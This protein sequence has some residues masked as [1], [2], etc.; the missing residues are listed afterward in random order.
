MSSETQWWVLLQHL[1]E[2]ESILDTADLYKLSQ[3][4]LKK[5]VLS[6]DSGKFASL[7]P[8]PNHLEQEVKVR[9]LLQ[10]VFER[11]RE[12]GKVYNRLVKV[13]SRLGGRVRDECD[14]MNREVAKEST[15]CG[16]DRNDEIA[17]KDVPHL[18][19]C[20]V[21]SSHL[22]EEIGIALEIPKY[23]QV[24]CGEGEDCVSRL[25]NIL[26]AYVQADYEGARSATL[27]RL[28]EALASDIVNQRVLAH[29]LQM[30][31]H[32]SRDTL[33]V[34]ASP[35]LEISDQSYDTEVT[36]GK[37]TLLEVQVCSSG[38]ESYQW[39]KDGQPLL[40]GADFSGVCS[41]ILYIDKASKCREGKYSCRVSRGSETECSDEISLS[42]V[43]PP[44]KR[45]LVKLYSGNK[46]RKLAQDSWPPTAHSD[47]INLVLVRHQKKGSYDYYTVRGD[48]D[49]ILESKE[50]TEYEKEFREYREGDLLLV[51]GRPG[52]G[53]TTLVHKLTRDWAEGKKVLQGARMVFLVT[54]RLANESGKDNSLLDLLQIFYGNVRNKEIEHDLQKCRGKGACFILDGLDEYPIEKKKNSVIDELLNTR[55][56]LP[57][58]MVI[59]ASRPVATKKLKELCTARV[60]VI[61]FH[62]DQIYSYVR[63]YP[64]LNSGMNIKMEEYLHQHPNVLHMCYLPV[65]AAMICFLFSKL[66]GD[67]P[68]TETQIYKQFTIATILRHEANKS[69]GLSK[70][71]SLMEL[72]GKEKTLFSSVCELAFDMMTNSQQVV[73]KSDI[74]ASFSSDCNLGLLTVER[75]SEHYGSEDLYTFHHLTF[76]E[77]LAAFYMI[78]AKVTSK[79]II[80]DWSWRNV[81]KFCCGLAPSSATAETVYY[82]HYT[83]GSPLKIQWAFESQHVDFCNSMVRDG[84]IDVPYGIISS[85]DSIALAYVISK[86]TKPVTKMTLDGF[87]WNS[88]GV[89]LFASLVTS[90]KLQSIKCLQARVYKDDMFKVLNSLLHHLPFLKELNLTNT[91]L[92]KYSIECLTS[93]ITLAHLEVLTISLPLVPCSNPGD[94]LKLLTFGSHNI[95]RV[96][97]CV[98]GGHPVNHVMW[99]KMLSYAFGCQAIQ[100]SDLSWLH[101]YNS[102][103]VPSL[104]HERLS[105]CTEV[106]LVNCCIGDE[107]AEILASTLNP[108][109]LEK[110]VLDFNR[111]GDSGAIA[112][113]GCLARCSVV[114]EVSIEC[115][116]IG[117]SGA[118]ALANALV[119]CTSLR[120][121]DLQ[122][123]SL[124]DKGAVATAKATENLPSLDLYLHNV[125]ITEE[126]IERVLEHRARANVRNM[127]FT[128]SWDDVNEADIDTLRRA[129]YCGNLP[130]L[131][132]SRKNIYNIEKLVAEQEQVK[133]VRGIVCEACDDDDTVTTQCRII[134]HLPYLHHVEYTS[135]ILISSSSAQLISDSLKGCKSLH[136]LALNS[137]YHTSIILDAVKCSTKLHSLDLVGCHIDQEEFDLLCSNVEFWVNLHTLNL[138]VC[139]GSN[140]DAF[141]KVLGHCKKL[142]HLYLTQNDVENVAALAEGLK[143]HTSLIEL[144]LEC[145]QFHSCMPALSH[146]IR[147]NHQLQCL[148][149]SGSSLSPEDMS[150]LVA[151]LCG[152]SLHSLD[153]ALTGL[154]DDG[155]AI[156]S[157]GLKKFTQ[158]VKLNIGRNGISSRGIECLSVGLQYCSKLQ[159]LRLSY[160]PIA[161]DGVK[162]LSEGLQYCSNLQVLALV[163]TRIS[164]D[165]V[166]VILDIMKGCKNLQELVLADNNIDMDSAARLVSGW[167]HK[168][169]LTLDLSDCFKEPHESALKEGSKCCESCD[170]LLQLYSNNDYVHIKVRNIFRGRQIKKSV[171]LATTN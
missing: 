14:A 68:Q 31:T 158:L 99:R 168:S 33:P 159:V 50:E 112:L 69:E 104:P 54:L 128:L 66:R 120:R 154:G 51:E 123:N 16:G 18:V 101:L 164:H 89:K 138:P 108:S 56:L 72:R 70:I 32:Q 71:K 60:E 15:T 29:K 111:I 77:F 84:N 133:N 61:G 151:A 4:L 65:H 130:A 87:I 37:S 105:H 62:K 53:K 132:L 137:R 129:L 79:R 166:S 127:V 94:V 116:S 100:D 102:E 122:G 41:N 2:L 85:T 64:F 144:K 19:K 147:R 8:D 169:L 5:K 155:I 55:T 152:D 27:R 148:D 30:P 23:K 7:D 81:W 48:M 153:F 113:A 80:K 24:D 9:Y 126:G 156:L 21:S 117:D 26:T 36:E 136:S 160:N 145:N 10:H 63:S 161:S 93:E 17:L 149:I 150:T 97:Y 58:S 118:T 140:F 131:K 35:Q 82:S 40:D 125:N 1:E 143:D 92:K 49:D 142:R 96:F 78:E 121:L 57:D 44:E 75:T 119:H 109:V 170:C 106:V 59:V 98:H 6:E 91:K 171:R 165:V 45:E 38:C 74:Q 124:G 95:Q 22:W 114:Q 146:V 103:T 39:S 43:Y 88:K 73:R 42:V 107:G 163:D 76:Q 167:Q 162:C 46:Q 20:L 3:D 139:H 25:N 110:L 135:G 67:I 141:N 134:E 86:C 157:A 13:L 34:S 12:D 90:D 52:S 11:V 83:I 115:N 47:V 28:K